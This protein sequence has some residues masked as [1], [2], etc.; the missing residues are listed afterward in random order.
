MVAFSVVFSEDK[1]R[2]ISLL[3]SSHLTPLLVNIPVV[4]WWNS[5]ILR[6]HGLAHIKV[7]RDRCLVEILCTFQIQALGFFNNDFC[8]M[9]E[10][11]AGPMFARVNFHHLQYLSTEFQ[12]CRGVAESKLWW[13]QSTS[14]FSWDS[15]RNECQVWCLHAT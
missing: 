12:G 15:L 10:E 6:I 14:T 2:I 11:A 7:L 8:M 3:A 5:F 13:H 9:R 4:F 1:F